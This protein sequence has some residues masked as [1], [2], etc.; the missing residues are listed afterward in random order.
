MKALYVI[1][2]SGLLSACQSTPEPDIMPNDPYY[3]PITAELPRQRITEDG[4]IF[5]AD[6]A[7]SLYSDVKAR[8]VGDIITVNLQE[9][10]RATKSAGTSTSKDSQV[11]VNPI[12]GLGG[13]A[14][15]IGSQ[16]VQLGVGATNEFSGDASANQSNNLSGNISVT[17]MKVFANQNLLVRGEKWLTLNNGNEYIRLTGVVRPAD[18]SPTNEI[19][20][21]KIANARIQYSGTGTFASAQKE[22]WLTRFFSSEYW[23]F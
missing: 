18:V 4:S 21:T 12:I 14:L 7:N 19:D 2:L 1:G 23:P 17:V 22:G 10:T 6:M 16:S 3:A 8:R 20:S 5:Q 13:N 15:N 11:D 9:N